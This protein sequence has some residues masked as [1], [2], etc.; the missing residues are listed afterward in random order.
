[1]LSGIHLSAMQCLTMDPGQQERP[2]KP[3]RAFGTL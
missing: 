2:A 3:L 1:L